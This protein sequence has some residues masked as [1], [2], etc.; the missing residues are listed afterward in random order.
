MDP[1]KYWPSY[2][3]MAEAVYI[4]WNQNKQ[5]CPIPKVNKITLKR[6]YASLVGE[7]SC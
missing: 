5:I 3:N 1:G 6:R 2:R 4:I 7:F